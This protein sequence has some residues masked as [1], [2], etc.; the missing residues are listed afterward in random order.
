M[1]T[2]QNEKTYY[3][4]LASPKIVPHYYKLQNDRICFDNLL[5][6]CLITRLLSFIKKLQLVV[7]NYKFDFGK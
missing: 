4:C 3:L 5:K 1:Y 6:A 7:D 2:Q